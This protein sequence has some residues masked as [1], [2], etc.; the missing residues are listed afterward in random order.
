MLLPESQGIKTIFQKHSVGKS[1]AG[2]ICVAHENLARLAGFSR[3][4][5]ARVDT[6]DQHAFP[7]LEKK[8]L[9]VR[10]P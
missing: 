7:G 4:F 1:A 10:C 6:I 8:W 9:V 5:D 3:I 2:E